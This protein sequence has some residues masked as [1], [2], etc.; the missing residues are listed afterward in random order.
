[1]L[2]RVFL[3][4]R[5]IVAKSPQPG[6]VLPG[7]KTTLTRK[8]QSG[9]LPGTRGTGLRPHAG[10]APARGV[11]RWAE[12]GRDPPLKSFRPKFSV[13]FGRRHHPT[14]DSERHGRRRQ[15]TG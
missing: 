9:I 15:P 13:S 2:G 11:L 6:I 3:R 7:T 8:P 5:A 1:M 10:D 12:G 4:G 14:G